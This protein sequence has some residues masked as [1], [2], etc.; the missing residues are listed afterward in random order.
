M[1]IAARLCLLAGLV[2]APAA[3]TM[4][5]GTPADDSTPPLLQIFREDVKPGRGAAHEANEG[6]WAAAYAKAKMQSGW[7]GTTSMTG[8]N[9]AWFFTGLSSWDE[10]EKITK[11]EDSNEA[12]SAEVKKLSA[13]D[14]E[15]LNKVSGIIARYAPEISYQP[16]VNLAQM[17]YMRVNIVRL[18]PGHGR[19]Y[20][21]R[22]KEIVAAHEKAKMD[23]HWAFYTVISGMATPTFL[24]FQPFKAL[25]EIDKGVPMHEGEPYRSAVGEDGRA[26]LQET[27]QTAV[28]WSQDIVLAFNPKMSYVPKTWVDA[29]PTFWAPK[30]AAPKKPGEK[31]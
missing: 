27:I 13:A 26:R 24:Y 28:E 14:G 15:L 23:E 25:A 8:P 17:R 18:K 12:L 10:W 29:D 6:A 5:Q 9:E 21:D 11:A 19:V 20:T 2:A 7:L 31:K 16:K 22:W 3:P 30:P 1:K 4:A